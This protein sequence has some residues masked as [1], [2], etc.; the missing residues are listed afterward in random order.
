MKKSDEDVVDLVLSGDIGAFEVLVRR[1]DA[2]LRRYIRRLGVT[3]P[4]DEDVLQDVFL[5]AYTN[6]NGYNAH[7]AF[8]S[9]IYRIAHNETI[10]Y[11][12]KKQVAYTFRN[13]QEEAWFWDGVVSEHDAISAIIAEEDE[14]TAT[15][16]RQWLTHTLQTIDIKYSEPLI[17]HFFEGKQYGEIADI[18]HI[19]VSTVGTRIRRAKEKLQLLYTKRN[20]NI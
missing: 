2:M 6:L 16:A 1:Y 9:W 15:E 3:P 11:H 12:R 4:R 13:D 14:W 7:Y 10:S 20:K 19:P 18:L 5:K 8:S 17:L